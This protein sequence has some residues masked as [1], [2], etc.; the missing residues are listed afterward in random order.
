[1][2]RDFVL[3]DARDGAADLDGATFPMPVGWRGGFCRN[4]SVLVFLK[5]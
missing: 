3:F 4:G 1:M 5:R 2:D